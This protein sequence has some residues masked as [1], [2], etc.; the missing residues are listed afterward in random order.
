ME[1]KD[2]KSY[3]IG[4]LG[5]IIGGLLATLPWVLCYVYG[6]MILS[7]LAIIIAI[8]AFKGYE[9]F[10]GKMDKAVPVII[11]VTSILCVTFA[12]FI[13]IPNLLILNEYGK[14]SMEAVKL[15]YA[16][17]E[18]RNALVGD[19][20]ISVLFTVLGM[21][22]VVASIKRSIEAGDEKI[23]FNKPIYSPN[24]EDIEDVRAFFE[25]KQALSKNSTISKDE[26]E[27][28]LS[29]LKE[30]VN[31]LKA[32]G[33]IRSYKGELYYDLEVEKNPG[34]RSLKIFL[35][36]F[37]VTIAVIILIAILL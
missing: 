17:D 8:G 24:N 37:G 32:R 11:G 22:G 7:A 9:L 3:A 6:E 23:S 13:V 4:T 29:D 5:A 35:I 36:T 30:V 12:T 15:L 10:K 28:N 31:F 21:S 34:K 20:V 27:K 33:I 26:V 2:F 16:F 25:K 18:F 1:K 14:T 19:Y